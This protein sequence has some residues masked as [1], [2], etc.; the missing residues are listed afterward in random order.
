MAR[1]P[2]RMIDI[3]RILSLSEKSK[4]HHQALEDAFYSL[5]SRVL[6]GGSVS[7]ETRRVSSYRHEENGSSASNIQGDFIPFPSIA[8]PPH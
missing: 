7:V 8:C 3:M 2:C 6:C 1:K 5:I 4:A